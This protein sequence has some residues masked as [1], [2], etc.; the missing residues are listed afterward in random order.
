MKVC[1]LPSDITAPKPP[2]YTPITSSIKTGSYIAI[3]VCTSCE[4]NF[5]TNDLHIKCQCLVMH[6]EERSNGEC[7]ILVSNSRWTRLWATAEQTGDN[8]ASGREA[9]SL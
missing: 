4:T 9:L 6:T 5:V 2:H 8:M 1:V 7:F 3:V